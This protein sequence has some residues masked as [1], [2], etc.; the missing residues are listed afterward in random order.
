MILM[1]RLCLWPDCCSLL[2]ALCSP[3]KGNPSYIG[4]AYARLG[5][6]TSHLP[7]GGVKSVFF[8]VGCLNWLLWL[9]SLSGKYCII[10]FVVLF[11][12][13]RYDLGVLDH[14]RTVGLLHS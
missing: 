10:L 13:F 2:F 14:R 1:I 4:L 12:C 3:D 6:G 5:R 8:G 7:E 9:S 11:L